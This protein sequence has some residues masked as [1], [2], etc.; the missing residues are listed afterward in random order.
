MKKKFFFLI[1]SISSLLLNA[2]TPI[3]QWAKRIGGASNDVGRSIVLDKYGNVYT[4]GIFSGTVDFDPG[5]GVYSLTASNAMF[6]SKLDPAGNFV[7]AKNMGGGSGTYSIALDTSGNIYTTGY[8]QGTVDFNPNVGTFYLTSTVTFRTDVFISKLDVFGNF[9]WAK[10]MG[11]GALDDVGRSISTDISGNVYT[12]GCFAGI[13][14]FDPGVGVYNLVSDSSTLNVF[15]SKL[16]SSGNFVWARSIGNTLDD[17]AYSIKVDASGNVYTT[18]YYQGTVDFDPSA[19]V[20]DLIPIGSYDIF[21]LKLN[22]SGNFVWA[23]SIGGNA[24]GDYGYSVA[25]DR[26]GNVYTSGAFNGTGDF[27]PG[28][29]TFSLTSVG[30]QDTFL[31]KLDSLGN[32]VWAKR[33]GGSG[34]TSAACAIALDTLGNVYTTGYFD[35]TA[36]DFDPGVGIYTL[37]ASGGSGSF[38]TFLLKL[39]SAGN[40][41]WAEN[42]TGPFNNGNSLIV[43]AIGNIYTTGVF[44]STNDFDPGTGIFNLTSSGAEDA[45][46]HKISQGIPTSMLSQNFDGKNISIY[47]NPSKGSITISA[48]EQIKNGSLEI[49]NSIGELVFSQKIINQQNL[50]D[51][52]DQA[53]GLYFVKMISNGEMIGMQKVVKE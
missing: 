52:K 8:F 48:A 47:P 50:I 51:L 1:F 28:A 15:I 2:Q 31:S 9:V 53:N 43:D 42:M 38:N 10:K 25:L 36:V 4:T 30:A 22:P 24:P 26:V 5:V 20:F 27:D 17:R 45:F 18:G 44:Q 33:I 3:F 39:D 13:V 41:V 23:K 14:D 49:Y 37:S 6:I 11:G 21:I 46:I 19:G 12:T 40:F 29:G 7:W 16:D 32:F 34:V 35:R